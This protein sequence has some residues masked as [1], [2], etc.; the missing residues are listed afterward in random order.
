MNMNQVINMVMRV[1]MR[2]VINSGITAGMG[3]FAKRGGASKQGGAGP[4]NIQASTSGAKTMTKAARR[5]TRM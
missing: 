4:G 1:I 2:R 3:A 5:V